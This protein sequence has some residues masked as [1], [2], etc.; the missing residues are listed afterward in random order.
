MYVYLL[1]D[2]SLRSAPADRRKLVIQVRLID[3]NPADAALV[4]ADGADAALHVLE[5]DFE[6]HG[7]QAVGV[8]VRLGGRE[9]RASEHLGLTHF[10]EWKMY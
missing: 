3:R 9:R 2:T 1:L 7:V 4:P 5:V 10:G 6:P 8:V